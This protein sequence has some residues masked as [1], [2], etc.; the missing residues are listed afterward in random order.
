MPALERNCTAHCMNTYITNNSDWVNVE[1]TISTAPDQIAVAPGSLECEWNQNG[2]RYFKYKLDHS[3]LNF[4]SF[5]SA[6]YTVARQEWNGIKIEVYYLKEQPWNV[7][8]MLRS[9][10]KSLEY[11]TKNFGPYPQK[12]VR[13]LEFPRIAA[14]CPGLPRHHALLGKHRLYR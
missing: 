14:L 7:P 3:A 4:Y 9:V 8:K 11:Y 2:R 6:D 12:E 5:L 13:I 10:E 1:T